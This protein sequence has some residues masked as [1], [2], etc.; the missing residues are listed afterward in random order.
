M[1][2]SSI[3]PIIIV[4]ILIALNG[5]F[6]AAEF[7]IVG[8]SKAELA[9]RGF[10]RRRSVVLAR[11]ILRDPRQ[12]DRFIATAQLG[13][14]AASLG[15]GMYGEHMLAEWIAHQLES[16]EVGRMLAAHTIASILA[17]TILTYFHIVLGEMVPK[18]LALQ[19][20]RETVL[21]IV[22]VMR[23]IQLVLWPLVITL[24]GIGNAVLRLFGI[25]RSASTESYRT[26][27]EI[28]FIVQ[29]SQTGGLLRGESAEVMREILEFSELTAG[30]VMVPRVRVTGVPIGSD[31]A[32]LRTL[33]HDEPH[34]R[35]P[36]YDRTLDRTLGVLHVRDIMQ[37]LESGAAVTPD[38]VRP[39]PFLPATATVERVLAA[40]REVRAQIAVIMDEHGGTAGIVTLEDLFEE[41]VGDLTE[42]PGEE[43]HIRTDVGGRLL[44]DGNARVTD[45]GE[46]L[47]VT[48]EHDDV[49]TVSGLV[50]ALLNRPPVAGDCVVF[51]GVR[52]CV[53]H[54]RE[55]GVETC[56]VE[57]V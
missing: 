46:E 10:E 6:V 45:V 43:E 13:I 39:A 36:V 1:S 11:A 54:V 9:R 31:T 20:A 15:L 22:P 2:W 25:E 24:N 35:Y 27:D 38:I 5:L 14:T 28:A 17:I 18:A 29:E 42:R 41:V 55:H 50:L 48:L 49:D 19:R 8:V 40:M 32:F 26:P 37:L 21:W 23:V 16:L 52:F 53:T 44:V 47:G 56:S 4:T 57:L 7:A 33:L 30:E 51:D 12:Q 34:T 3:V